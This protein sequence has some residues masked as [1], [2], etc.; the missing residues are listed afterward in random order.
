MQIAHSPL[1]TTRGLPYPF[2]NASAHHAQHGD[3]NSI[4]HDVLRLAL[5][6]T[7]SKQSKS[8]HRSL[9][10]PLTATM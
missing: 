1:L 3:H 9:A 7:T 2:N 6:A 10:L 4:L 8:A 5:L